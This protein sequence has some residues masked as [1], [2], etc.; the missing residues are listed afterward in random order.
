MRYYKW[1]TEYHSNAWYKMCFIWLFFSE[2]LLLEKRSEKENEVQITL[3][4]P[5][6]GGKSTADDMYHSHMLTNICIT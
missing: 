5:E 3:Y 1:N 2:G 6:L 4:K